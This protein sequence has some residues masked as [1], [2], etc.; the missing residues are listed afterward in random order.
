VAVIGENFKT[1]AWNAL[2]RARDFLKST[3]APE[4]PPAD[5]LS[6]FAS[7]RRDRLLAVLALAL[8]VIT[9]VPLF[10]TP[11]LP[12]P[13]LHG[14]VGLGS[15]LFDARFGEGLARHHYKIQ[16]LPV[17]NWTTYTFIWVSSRLFGGL[18]AAK[19]IVALTALALPLATM[20]LLVALGRDPR[21]GLWAFLLSWEH[22]LYS[23]WFTYGLSMSLALFAL[24]WLL[25]AR[26]L[27]RALRVT[28]LG[29]VLGVTHPLGVIFFGLA[30]LLTS[31]LARRPLRRL[32]VHT[33]GVLG[34]TIVLMPWFATRLK[35]S[36]GVSQGVSSFTFEFHTLEYKLNNFFRFTLNNFALPEHVRNAA[37]GFILLVFGP[38]LLSLLPARSGADRRVPIAIFV[39]A[40]L[41]YFL[42][43]MTTSGPI[44]HWYTYPR[45]ASYVLVALMMIPAPDLQQL[46]ALTLIPGIAAVLL[47]HGTVAAQ[48]T[49]FAQRARPFLEIIAEVRP[50]SSY[51]PL[52]TDQGDP[53][54]KFNPYNQIHGY[55]VSMKGGYDPHLFDNASLPI[56]YRPK[57]RLPQT[58]WN[59]PNAFS[60]ERHGQFYDYVLVQDFTKSDPVQRQPA[61]QNVRARLVREAGQFRLY[62]IERE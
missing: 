28:A 40:L 56:V 11:I 31:L 18:I 2:R 62:A 22:S 29:V 8:C 27:R 21:Q 20:R 42:M 30:A 47:V 46:R 3:F 9:L 32:L 4:P 43:P 25:E 24:A 23:G 6:L 19:L 53:A 58:E 59:G 14:N 39:T 41:L 10:V 34:L 51:L 49:S 37:I 17:P 13:D 45:Y 52:E 35:A 1:S 50:N 57:R 38:V 16:W 61:W 5:R 26:T 54:M 48:L 12:F 15:L 55:I 44:S 7:F 33:V 36:G 60:L